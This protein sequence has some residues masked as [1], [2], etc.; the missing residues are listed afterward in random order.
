MALPTLGRPMPKLSY[1]AF[2][3][4][5]RRREPLNAGGQLGG[6]NPRVVF[7]IAGLK[8]CGYVLGC[9]AVVCMGGL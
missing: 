5:G 1:G 3:V 8:E 2:P 4:F 9:E 6:G 7:L